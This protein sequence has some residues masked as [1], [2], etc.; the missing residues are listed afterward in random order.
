MIQ[1]NP[2]NPQDV[3]ASPASLFILAASLAKI[4]KT[5]KTKG[6]HEPPKYDQRSKPGFYE[7]PDPFT[8]R[9][10]SL[11]KIM[12]GP[13]HALKSQGTYVQAMYGRIS[14][15]EISSK[16]SLVSFIM[17]ASLC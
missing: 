8:D 15:T 1:I 12:I 10:T 17:F 9:V 16:L 5:Q 7:P 11:R 13:A 6:N 4:A 14:K 3:A 2:V